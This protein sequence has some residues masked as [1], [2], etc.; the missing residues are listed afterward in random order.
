M[1]DTTAL[2]G[3]LPTITFH[4]GTRQVY[5]V[6]RDTCDA[7]YAACTDHHPACDCREAERSENVVELRGT[8][9]GIETAVAEVL[10]GHQTWAYTQ[11]GRDTIAECKCTGCRIVRIADCGLRSIS[12]VNHEREAAGL[13]WGLGGEE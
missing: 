7:R 11:T 4:D 6:P 3:P 2:V 9:R 12:Q 1:T 10:A 13:P 5:A 8:I